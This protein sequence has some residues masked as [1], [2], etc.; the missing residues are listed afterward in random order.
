MRPTTITFTPNHKKAIEVILWFCASNKGKI[1]QYNLL[2]ALFFA[3]VEHLNRYGRPIVGDTYQAMKYG[4]VPS[5]VRDLIIQNSLLMKQYGIRKLPFH[6]N[7]SNI[8][9]GNRAPD[10]RFFSKSDIGCLEISFQKYGK[11]PFGKLCEENHKH[12]AWKETWEKHPNGAI[13]FELL[14]S[15]EDLI[16]DLRETARDMVI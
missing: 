6:I 3:E 4:T 15:D 1:N 5:L 7:K 12:K 2:K 11:M 13:P 10:L 8:I 9:E 16:E 14:I